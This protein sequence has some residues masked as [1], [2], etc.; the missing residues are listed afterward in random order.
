MGSAAPLGAASEPRRRRDPAG[1][2]S[3]IAVPQGIPDRTSP[4][5]QLGTLRTHG[6]SRCAR[7]P[8]HASGRDIM[9]VLDSPCVDRRERVE[10]W[11]TSLGSGFDRLA[12]SS[13]ART[14]SATPSTS[15]SL[16]RTAVRCARV[17]TGAGESTATAMEAQGLPPI[18]QPASCQIGRASCRERVWIPV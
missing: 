15:G 11:P 10:P 3:Q 17:T 8:R 13:A 14:A 5:R 2:A 9:T 1:H 7:D 18:L 6:H 4:N 12:G 16:Y